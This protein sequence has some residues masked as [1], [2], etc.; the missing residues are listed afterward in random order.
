M[1]IMAEKWSSIA[2]VTENQKYPDNFKEARKGVLFNQ[3]HDILSG[4]SIPSA[5]EDASYLY[6]QAAAIGQWNLNYAIQAISWDIDIETD[7]AM[8]PIV[9]FNSAQRIRSEATVNGQSR[10]LFAAELPSMG[11]R[12]FKLYMNLDEKQGYYLDKDTTPI[13]R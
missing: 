10:L 1:L 6:G 11:Y 9:V 8:K 13:P 12:V 3:F 2:N 4:T 5:Y 7:V